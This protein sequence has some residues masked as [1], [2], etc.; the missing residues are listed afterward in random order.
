MDSKPTMEEWLLFLVS[1]V[2]R[3]KILICLKHSRKV[4]EFGL[5]IYSAGISSYFDVFS[6]SYTL[7]VTFPGLLPSESLLRIEFP[8]ENLKCIYRKCSINGVLY[9]DWI[10]NL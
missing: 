2:S 8:S 10:A 3:C 6:K 9:R 1:E 4:K 5:Y 7:N